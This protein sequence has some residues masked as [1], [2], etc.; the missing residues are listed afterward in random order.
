MLHIPITLQ[1]MS[2]FCSFKNRNTTSSTWETHLQLT[3]KSSGAKLRVLSAFTQVCIHPLKPKPGDH[4]AVS[5]IFSTL[6]TITKQTNCEPMFVMLQ[7]QNTPSCPNGPLGALIGITSPPKSTCREL[8]QYNFSSDLTSYKLYAN[9]SLI[10]VV[11]FCHLCKERWLKALSL[12]SWDFRS[13]TC[14]LGTASMVACGTQDGGV[15]MWDAVTGRVQTMVGIHGWEEQ[16]KSVAARRER[17][18]G[19]ICINWIWLIIQSYTIIHIL[20]TV[21][22]LAVAVA[23]DAKVLHVASVSSNGVL[24]ILCTS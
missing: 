21:T 5:V 23:V 13:A 18:R 24:H 1:Y 15:V 14:M 2:F 10:Q 11:Q 9:R 4:H 22:A 19:V 16:G 17:E 7:I 12:I 8:L 6:Y 20:Y 3:T